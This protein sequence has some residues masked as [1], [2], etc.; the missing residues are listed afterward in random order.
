MIISGVI[1]LY[2]AWNLGDKLVNGQ[3][4]ILGLLISTGDLNLPF[5]SIKSDKIPCSSNLSFTVSL[6]SKKM[7]ILCFDKIRLV[8]S[9][10]FV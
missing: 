2:S 9:W 7:E 3:S 4:A 8:Y 6:N 10:K 5:S 1:S